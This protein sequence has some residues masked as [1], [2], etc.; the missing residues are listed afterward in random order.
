M[1]QFTFIDFYTFITFRKLSDIFLKYKWTYKR[2]DGDQKH[3]N[4][5]QDLKWILMNSKGNYK[6]YE[7]RQPA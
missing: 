6:E 3:T 7:H 2:I 4:P 1:T 5:E